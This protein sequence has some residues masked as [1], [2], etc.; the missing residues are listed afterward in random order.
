MTA[1]SGVDVDARAELALA[2][3]NQALHSHAGA[4]EQVAVENG[5]VQLRYTGMCAGCPFR[6]LTTYATVKPLFRHQFG[7]E[8]EVIGSRISAEAEE[9]VVAA[10]A[11]T[12]LCPAV[13]ESE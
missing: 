5:V 4:L 6:P 11:G 12:G 10:Y 13:D 3:V 1:G 2:T 8:V 9:R 7:L